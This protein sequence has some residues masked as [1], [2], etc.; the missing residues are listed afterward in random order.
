MEEIWKEIP[1]YNGIYFVSNKGRVKSVDHYLDGRRGSGKQNGRFLKFQKDKKGYLR[2]SLSLN[3]K[4]FQTGVHRLVANAFIP[5][6]D[7]KPQVNHK[8]GDKEN[9]ND[10]NLEWNTNQEN[11][12]HAVL[13]GLV[14]PNYGEK[15]HMAKLS[16]ADVLKVRQL[17][18]IGFTN[19]ELSKDFG[20]SEPAMSK[21][22][23]RETYINI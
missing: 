6:P 11:Q 4:R 19:K 5:N 17:H 9:N 1:G 10:W 21:I 12:I 22:L 23:R 18:S 20:V 16:N 7:N 8:D 14:K 2:A 15:H 3:K 13:N